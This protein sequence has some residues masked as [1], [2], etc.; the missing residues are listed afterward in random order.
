MAWICNGK[1]ASYVLGI[2][3]E[4]GCCVYKSKAKGGLMHLTAKGHRPEAVRC[5]RPPEVRGE[6][7]P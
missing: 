7:Y 6:V 4:P 1:V 3:I 5:I 2:K